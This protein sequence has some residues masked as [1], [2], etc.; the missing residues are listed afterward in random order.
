MKI[1]QFVGS[2]LFDFLA[3]FLNEI[4]DKFD[5]YETKR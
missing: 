1:I 2:K 3:S 4:R 5:N